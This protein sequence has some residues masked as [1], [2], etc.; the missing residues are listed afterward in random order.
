MNEERRRQILN[1]DEKHRELPADQFFA[2]A[3]RNGYETQDFI[4]AEEEPEE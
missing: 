3:E 1:F 4:D 2:L